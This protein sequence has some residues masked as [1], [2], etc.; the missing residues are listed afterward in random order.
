M[1]LRI[2][3]NS[4]SSNPN[5]INYWLPTTEEKRMAHVLVIDDDKQVRTFVRKCL[6]NS[7]HEVSELSDGRQALERQRVSPADLVITDIFMPGQDGLRTI[8]QLLEVHPKLHVIAMSGGAAGTGESTWELVRKS[9]NSLGVV[10]MLQ[11][12]F[13]I[14]ELE[15]AGV[16]RSAKSTCA[17]LFML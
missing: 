6:E 2:D 9:T 11:K 10:K 4:K 14:R 15:A 5:A 1:G 7:N 13:R 17:M 3:V 8:I 16:P 12:P